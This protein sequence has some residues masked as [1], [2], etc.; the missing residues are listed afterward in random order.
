[1]AM[2]KKAE[3]RQ[4]RIC[5]CTENHACSGGCYWVEDGLCS[6]CAD[7]RLVAD[8]RRVKGRRPDAYS[9]IGAVSGLGERRIREIAKGASMDFYERTILEGLAGY[10]K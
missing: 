9:V 3:E 10:P 1:M 4:C 7:K 2:E 6:A 5:G 8:L